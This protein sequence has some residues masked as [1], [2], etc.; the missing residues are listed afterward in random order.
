MRPLCVELSAI[1]GDECHPG[2]HQED[3]H[4]AEEDG[5]EDHA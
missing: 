2:D 3:G 1:A 4:A 5:V